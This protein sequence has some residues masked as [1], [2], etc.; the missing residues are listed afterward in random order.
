MHILTHANPRGQAW[1]FFL[2]AHDVQTRK[3]PRTP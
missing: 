2:H 3:I 1:V